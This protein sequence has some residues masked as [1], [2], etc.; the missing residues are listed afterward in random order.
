MKERAERVAAGI[1]VDGSSPQETRV[2]RRVSFADV[3][4]AELEHPPE[5]QAANATGVHAA[6]RQAGGS[7]ARR[8]YDLGS[9]G[10]DGPMEEPRWGVAAKETGGVPGLADVGESDGNKENTNPAA[11]EGAARG[12]FGA[13]RQLE[14]LQDNTNN[15]HSLINNVTGNSVCGTTLGG[16]SQ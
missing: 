10:S 7:D 13:D 8:R 15:G 3:E 4:S 5:Q 9:V 1:K 11:S 16:P 14:L 12:G 2:A 6:A